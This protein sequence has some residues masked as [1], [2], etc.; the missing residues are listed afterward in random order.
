[1]AETEGHQVG[2]VMGYPCQPYFQSYDQKQPPSFAATAAAAAA[3]NSGWTI[4]NNSARPPPDS[5]R[6]TTTQNH[7]E[8]DC[9][10]VTTDKKNLMM[11]A[12]LVLF[13]G[14]LALGFIF[15]R[16]SLMITDFRPP[17]FEVDAVTVYPFNISSSSHITASWNISLF[18][19]NPKS[20]SFYYEDMKA[21]VLL[22]NESIC[23]TMV[24]NLFIDGRY[25]KGMMVKA[26]LAASSVSMNQTV[27][28]AAIA[29]MTEEQAVSFS[30][31]LNV[32]GRM[33]PGNSDEKRKRMVAS[34]E[35]LK[36][37]FNTNS[38]VGKLMGSPIACNLRIYKYNME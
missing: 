35:D 28:E 16:A 32:I 3:S 7:A 29:E 4:R 11:E 27:A 37:G 1:M 36:V 15:W 22:K 25:E 24:G 12:L 20:I 30:F 9:S 2:I 31:M 23:S 33:D 21:S 13:A 19:E 5:Y 34:C 18:I 38:Q 8:L 6:M 26:N 14:I 17:K 10:N